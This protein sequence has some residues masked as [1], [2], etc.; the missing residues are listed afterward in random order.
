MPVTCRGLGHNCCN[1]AAML[2][3]PEQLVPFR[4]M[5]VAVIP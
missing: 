5:Q 4:T 3:L 2:D 1:A